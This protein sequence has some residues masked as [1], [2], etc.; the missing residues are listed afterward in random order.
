MQVPSY[1]QSNIICDY[2]FTSGT[3]NRFYP[4]YN[5][6]TKEISLTSTEETRIRFARSMGRPCWVSDIY[7]EAGET[8][9]IV[10]GNPGFRVL[11]DTLTDFAIE[12]IGIPSSF[13]EGTISATGNSDFY[14]L[15]DAT[16]GHELFLDFD[17]SNVVVDFGTSQTVS[18]SPMIEN[19]LTHLIIT[20]D[21]TT[22]S[23]T[24]GNVALN[25]Q[26][27]TISN[28][29]TADPINGDYT[30]LFYFS[31]GQ[32]FIFRVYNKYLSS[33]EINSLF[34]NAKKEFEGYNFY[35]TQTYVVPV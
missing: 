15:Y 7:F 12:Y 24:A 11:G 9:H 25:G 27:K 33:S 3:F 19:R 5:A 1:L 10:T 22:G 23:W 26:V 4:G 6:S 32:H 29:G 34:F 14:L 16:N 13:K 28:F 8:P 30:K 2:R 35:N 31:I 21:M 17:N 18:F 20:R